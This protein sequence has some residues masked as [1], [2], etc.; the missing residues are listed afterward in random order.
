MRTSVVLAGV[1]W[2]LVACSPESPTG[3]DAGRQDAAALSDAAPDIA[4][5]LDAA[6]SDGATRDAAD[7]SALRV[8]NWLLTIETAGTNRDVHRLLRVSVAT[9]DYGAMSEIC[10]NITMPASVPASNIISS[11]TF[12]Q[13]RLLASGRTMADGDTMFEIDPCRCTATVVGQYGY[14]AVP[15][16]T[17]I[18][19][20]L[21]GVTTTA[22]LLIAINPMTAR[23]TRLGALPSDWGTAGL[24]WSGPARNSLYGIS[25]SDDTLVEFDARTGAVIGAPR[26]LD[27]DFGSVGMEFHPGL[28]RIYGCSTAG[29]LL[30]VDAA[31]GHVTV[32]PMLYAPCNNLAAPFG[33]VACV[34]G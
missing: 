5:P 20:D 18:G 14:D 11:L 2:S 17:S 8:P 22:D 3:P 15:G 13:G 31:T 26:T 16:I 25:G 9:A 21:F 1:C 6:S 24:S 33:S 30:E 12:N 27:Y 32:G 19:P 29:N 28:D 23:S 34:P 7:A 10:A 4:T